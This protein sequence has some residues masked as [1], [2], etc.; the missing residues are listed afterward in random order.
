MGRP[1]GRFH[2]VALAVLGGALLWAYWPALTA[3][4]GR[5]TH[6]PKY[7]H[8]YLVPAFALFL[9][10]F[11]RDRIPAQ[12]FRPSWWGVP[13]MAAGAALYL[14][15]GKLFVTFFDGLSLL[16]VLAGVCVLL[17]GRPCLRWA[18][19]AV[20]F[21]VFMLPLPYRLEVGF[22]YPL[23]RL[24]TEASTYLLQT[25]GYPALAQG[26]IIRVEGIPDIGVVEA[27]NGL[28][29]LITFCA[30]STGVA[31]VLPQGWLEKAVVLASAI[32][33]ALLANVTR[34]LVFVILY[35][36]AGPVWA[37]DFFHKR[38]G[39]LMMPLALAVL[40]LELR[41]VAGLFVEVE[42]EKPMGL[43][44][45]GLN[46]PGAGAPAERVHAVN[47]PEAPATR[48]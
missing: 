21:L 17:G 48:K 34:I 5:W 4:A 15:G 1:S 36:R 23:Q 11:R 44:L 20:A 7:S 35:K 45:L 2:L 18:W 41:I 19:P 14:L 10:W 12:G 16:P 25:L 38:A 32:P 31:V 42:P 43:D 30:L 22:A 9:L 47:K 40:W 24:A 27:C 33:I 3:M 28:S 29:M 6:D 46:P 8:G 26:N 13:V 39:W 37:D